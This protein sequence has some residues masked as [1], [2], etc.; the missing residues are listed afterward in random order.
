M[1]S[2]GF[3]FTCLTA[4]KYIARTLFGERDSFISMPFDTIGSGAFIMRKRWIKRNGECEFDQ[5]KKLKRQTSFAFKVNKFSCLNTNRIIDHRLL[6]SFVRCRFGILS[7]RIVC[8]GE[9]I[10]PFFFFRNKLYEIDID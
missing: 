3:R 9:K 10:H 7:Y 8:Y 2:Y 1:K 5:K 4:C 6:E